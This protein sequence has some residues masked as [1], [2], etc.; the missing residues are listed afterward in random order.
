MSR[1]GKMPIS[2][3]QGLDFSVTA[4]QITVKGPLGTLVRP[5]SSLVTISN[6]A[7]KLEFTPAND[8]TAADA[9]SGTMRALV[10]NMVG[11]VTKGFEKRLS[12]VGV[13]F[14][15]QAAGSKLNLQIGFSHPVGKDMPEG[16]KVECPTPT[17]I[18]IFSPTYLSP[19]RARASGTWAKRSRSKRPRRSKERMT[20]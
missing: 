8:T 16:V 17:E 19:T 15:A 13:G 3:P 14:K 11:G 18:V 9:M 12:L 20:C 5:A 7:G 10:A 4:D 6:A 2:L 1:V